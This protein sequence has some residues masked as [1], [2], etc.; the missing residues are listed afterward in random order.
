[1]AEKRKTKRQLQA[2]ETKKRIYKTAME[3][4]KTKGFENLTIQDINEHAGVSVGTFYHYYKSKEDVFFELYRNADEYFEEQVLPSM[5]AEEM[6]SIERIL[7]FF[8]EYARFN[9]DNG[10]EYVK[11]LYNTNNKFFIS[12]DRY[13]LDLMYRIITEGQQAGE[14]NSEL[15]PEDMMEDLFIVSRGIIFDWCLHDGEY[16]LMDKMHIHLKR[17]LSVFKSG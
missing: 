10:I 9:I 16:D 17:H 13:M 7:L 14:L 12:R 4:I 6:T 11:Q 1:M 5:Y 8:R 3:L 2:E 15:N